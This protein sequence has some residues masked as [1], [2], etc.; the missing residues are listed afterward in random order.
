MLGWSPAPN[1]VVTIL[2]DLPQDDF[3]TVTGKLLKEMRFVITSTNSTGKFLEFEA[4]REG[5]DPGRKFI[6]RA[7]RGTKKITPD[8]LQTIVGKKRGTAELSPVYIST[9]GFTEEAAKYGD[10]LNISL[11]DGDKLALLIQKYN[12]EEDLEKRANTKVLESEGNRFLPSIDE[13]E[14]NMKWGNDFFSSGNHRKA[15]EYYDAALRLKSQ[16]DL[17]WLMKGNAQSA[18]GLYDEAIESFTKVLEYNPKSEE[19]WYNLGATLYSMGRYDDELACYDKAL[20]LR[21][22]Y[23]K[24]WNNKGATLH[25][26]GKFEEAV[27]CYDRVLKSEPDNVSVLNNRGVALKN[28]KK[29]DEALQ[30]FNRALKIRDDYMDA[31]LN[32]G[33]LLHDMERYQEAVGCYDT[34]LAKWRSP[35]VLCQKGVA[36]SM[37]GKYRLAIE[38]FDE[39]LKLKPDWDIAIEERAK[40]E[41]ALSEETSAKALKARSEPAKEPSIPATQPEIGNVCQHCGKPL[42][43]EARFCAGCGTRIY[44]DDEIS[45]AAVKPAILES[46]E[47]QEAIQIAM[48]RETYL[49]ERSRLLRTMDRFDDALKSVNEALGISEMPEIWLEKGNVLA[50]MGRPEEAIEAYDRVIKAEPKNYLAWSNKEIV[51]A[52]MGLIDAALEANSRV[53]ELHPDWLQ[54]WLR[55]AGMLMT[56]GRTDKAAQCLDRAS[57][58][59]PQLA[60]VWNEQGAA[61]LKLGKTDKA[62]LCLDRAL[63]IDPDF[64][65]AWANRGAAMAIAG[66]HDKSLSYFDRAI[67]IDPENRDAWA[68]KGSALY[69]TGRLAE[70][71]ECYEEALTVTRS[72][73]LLNS[74]G[75]ALLGADNPSAA[76]EA[77]DEA[78]AIDPEYADAWNNRGL[79]YTRMENLA[80]AY[81]SFDRALAIAP[82]FAD[83]RKNRDTA[84]RNIEQAAGKKPVKSESAAIPASRLKG[85]PEFEKA[86]KE[87][88]VLEEEEL[89]TEEFRCPYCNAL[90][91]I[92]DVFCEKCGQKFNQ[93]M[94]E[95]AVQEKLEDLLDTGE[96]KKETVKKKSGRKGREELIED[97]VT[98]PGVGF[99]KA[100]LI[101]DAGY[102]SESKLRK[103]ETGELA[104][105]SGIG[106]GLAKRIKRKYR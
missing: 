101:I 19:A 70:A 95:D 68:N 93:D 34:V 100:G 62:L 37:L 82:E 8:E 49:L 5:D 51:L 90:G 98:V 47:E 50:A 99:A 39:S 43:P 106:E 91:S 58:I 72:K 96:A 10:M 9:G 105:I 15:I 17:A 83:A 1:R 76:A 79:A 60:E 22:D 84:A 20:E 65:E 63:Q 41:K 14:N 16:Y 24:A 21:P 28:L 26:M 54:A 92:E 85:K 69:N 11:A 71:I 81:D 104:E 38:S 12:M 52:G 53:T 18:L 31:C 36:L 46:I 59:A 94:K 33:I 30:S 42:S 27:M 97:L 25:Q 75:W 57:E 3:L 66:Q 78:L 67:D 61:L 35:E 87:A 6:I 2:N 55:R 77:F 80:E 64:S 45:P 29:Y 89:E 13:L 7:T 73:E 40:A 74:M 102:D 86:V 103:A 32:K 44:D 4:T 48:D 23:S 88:E 56:N